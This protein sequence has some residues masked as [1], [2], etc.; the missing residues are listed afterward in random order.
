VLG[1]KAATRATFSGK[2]RLDIVWRLSYNVYTFFSEKGSTEECFMKTIMW[3]PELW[4][5][6]FTAT[7]YSGLWLFVGLAQAQG[8]SWTLRNPLPT[9]EFLQAV[10]WSGTQLAA[11]GQNGA[12]L[13]SPNGVAWTVRSSGTTL[14]M[15]GVVWTGSQFVAVGDGGS[16]RT[17]TDGVAWS[18]AAELFPSVTAAAAPS[19][20]P[21]RDS[22]INTKSSVRAVGTAPASSISHTSW[23]QWLSAP[24]RAQMASAWP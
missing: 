8:T 6:V 20:T 13:T 4:K 17:S 15:T 5:R 19:P 11:V 3:L 9:N 1:N 16:I 7:A 10:A 18:R 12:V 14:A 23:K 24:P 21:R 2:K 22:S